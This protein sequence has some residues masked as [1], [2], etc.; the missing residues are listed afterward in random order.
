MPVASEGTEGDGLN[1]GPN[2]RFGHVSGDFDPFE[3]KDRLM[4]IGGVDETHATLA[5][6]RAQCP[7]ALGSLSARFGAEGVDTLLYGEGEQATTFS[8]PAAEQVL[9]DPARFSASWYANV[10]EM[11]GRTMIEMDTPE[12]QRYRSLIQPAFTKKVVDA[13][14]DDWVRDMVDGII[15]GFIDDKRA[16][17]SHQFAFDYPM[18]VIARAAGVADEDF[19]EFHRDSVIMF[20]QGLAEQPR[21][22]AAERMGAHIQRM[23][24]ERRAERADD[25]VSVLL[26][27]ELSLPDHTKQR[28][29]DEEVVSFVRL[30]VPSGSQTVYRGITN[31]MFGLLTHPEQLDAVRNDRSL[32]PMAIEEGLRWEPPVVTTVRRV[33]GATTIEGVELPADGAIN[34]CLASGNRDDSRW[35]RPEEFDI[36]RTP[37]GHLSFGAGPHICLGIHMARM[38]MR[39]AIEALLDRLPGLRLDPGADSTGVSG[40][41]YRTADRLPVVWD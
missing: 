12:H 33:T 4:G 26:A 30:L 32:I 18:R 27:A 29:D 10:F 25:L 24:V 36:A 31:T 21:R 7:V 2:G 15:D 13:W 8:F 6:L 14:G 34:V 20:N 39:I 28:L 38:E 1:G 35:E 37:H 22:E 41:H 5:S 16:E 3:A 23:I 9:K 17:L 19:T 40:L 11:V